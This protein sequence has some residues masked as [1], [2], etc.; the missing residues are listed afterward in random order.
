V[1]KSTLRRFESKYVVDDSG[2]WIWMAS[3]TET[4]YGYFTVAGKTRRAHRVSYEHHVGPIPDGLTIDHLCRVRWCV[5]PDH[6]EP[7]TSAEN[8]RRRPVHPNA[9]K[10]HC[11]RG[12][13]YLPETTRFRVFDD[14]RTARECLTCKRPMDRARKNRS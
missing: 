12:H 14:G 4:G 7:V 10:T 6:M 8:T 3:R 1:D 2:C 5:N 9:A 13:E 11:K